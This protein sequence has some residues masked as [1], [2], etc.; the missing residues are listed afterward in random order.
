M[1]SRSNDWNSAH[2]KHG[3]RSLSMR[4]LRADKSLVR[5]VVVGR[6]ELLRMYWEARFVGGGERITAVSILRSAVDIRPN[7]SGTGV[8]ISDADWKLGGWTER[9]YTKRMSMCAKS[10]S[11]VK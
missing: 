11:S 2:R 4:Q 5:F 1:A 7:E 8:A 3:T 9:S 6:I 10:E